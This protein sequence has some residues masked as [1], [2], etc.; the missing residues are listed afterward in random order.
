MAEMIVQKLQSASISNYGRLLAPFKKHLL[1][2]YCCIKRPTEKYVIIVTKVK[3]TF[4]LNNVLVLQQLCKIL[5]TPHGGAPKT[6]GPCNGVSRNSFSY[7]L[8]AS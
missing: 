4:L 8:E 5:F 2:I 1:V 3:T 7:K 6:M